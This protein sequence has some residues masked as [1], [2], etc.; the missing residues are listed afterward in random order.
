VSVHEPVL[1]DEVMIALMPVPGKTYVDATV[2]AGGHARGILER[3]GP[4]ARL[5]GL[6]LDAQALAQARQVLALCQAQV[7]LVQGSFVRLGDIA[8]EHRFAPADGILMDLGLSSMQLSEA[9]RGFSF[10]QD[11]PL[12][13]RFDPL[14]PQT[15]DE[16]V[17]TLST[18]ELADVLY[19]YGEE[20]MSRRIARAIVDAR[21]LHSTAELAAVVSRAVKWRG[22]IH[23]ATKTFQALRIAV[24]DELN[25]LQ[26][27]LEQ[28][29]ETLSLG[30]RL[31]VITFHSLEDRIVKRFFLERSRAG[32]DGRAPTLSVVTR[33]PIRATRA[34]QERNPRSRSAKLRVATRLAACR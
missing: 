4:G 22:R 13:M 25:V 9:A 2:G 15:A 34:E 10:R 11:G 26:Q 12:D 5:L 7:V 14:S 17:N 23:P 8:R 29:V 28:A 6:D 24:N 20:T 21:P 19:R 1:F 30:G 31:A 27:G 32:T 16:L 33:H 18:E 3:S